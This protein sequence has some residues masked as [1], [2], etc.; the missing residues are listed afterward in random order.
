MKDVMAKITVA[1]M[2]DIE[3]MVARKE[4]SYSRMIEMINE[5][6]DETKETV[7]GRLVF[8]VKDIMPNVEHG[9]I[10]SEEQFLEDVTHWTG[11]PAEP[12]F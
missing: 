9:G 11:L 3:Q 12:N 5:K 4:I 8:N 7:G 6:A 1:F 10:C 2:R